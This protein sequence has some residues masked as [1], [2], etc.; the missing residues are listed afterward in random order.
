MDTSSDWMT[1]P[2]F[3]VRFGEHVRGKAF[4]RKTLID[5]VNER[6]GPPHVKIGRDVCYSWSAALKWLEQQLD[7][8]A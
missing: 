3:A 2:E 5:W 7:A 1:Q 6:R 4:N 8:A